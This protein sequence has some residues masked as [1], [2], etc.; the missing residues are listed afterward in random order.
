VEL[1]DGDIQVACQQSCPTQAIVFGDLA[2]PTSRVARLA[3]SPRAYGVLTE[4][5]VKPSVSYLARIRNVPAAE[6]EEEEQHAR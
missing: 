5:N 3:S 4:L 2:D 6:Q 1:V